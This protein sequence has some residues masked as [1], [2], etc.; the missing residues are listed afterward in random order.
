MPTES[1]LSSDFKRITLASETEE[2]IVALLEISH[3]DLVA[4][5]RISSDMTE[6]KEYDEGSGDPI[7]ITRH[8][9]KEFIAMP[10][11]FTPPGTPEDGKMPQA[12]LT[13]GVHPKIIQGIRDIH[14]RLTL[15]VVLVYASD[16]DVIVGSIPQL[17]LESVDYDA[18]SIT[19]TLGFKHFLNSPVPVKKFVPSL[20]P[21]LFK[22]SVSGHAT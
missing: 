4:P 14:D 17:Q 22:H 1:V 18:A 8:Q 7:Y 5:I 11:S 21:G 12:K 15:K 19:A 3:P 10:F 16:P 2:V 9:G 6:I 20:F 13:V